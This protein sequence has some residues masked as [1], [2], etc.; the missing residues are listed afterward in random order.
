MLP[1][2]DELQKRYATFSD[3]KL[4]SLLHNRH[5]YT[6]DALEVAQAELQKRKFDQGSIDLLLA[7][8][9][10]EAFEQQAHAKVRGLRPGSWLALSG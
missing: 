5:E 9:E 7:K 8:K 4:L 1:T 10:E 2:K 3:E 6:D